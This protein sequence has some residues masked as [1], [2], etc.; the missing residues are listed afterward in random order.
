MDKAWNAPSECRGEERRHAEGRPR[1]PRVSATPAARALIAQL[2]DAHGR[3]MLHQADGGGEPSLP[4]CFVQGDFPLVEMDVLLGE[5]DGAPFYVSHGQFK[6]YK[7]ARV[8]LDVV[9]GRGGVFSLER[10]TGLRFKTEARPYRRR[11]ARM[12]GAEMPAA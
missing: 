1:T 12:A 3:V 6:R 9:Q 8:S 11:S 5:I 2:Q 10:P 7:D 4:M